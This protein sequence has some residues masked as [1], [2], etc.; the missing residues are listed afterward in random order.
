MIHAK[1]MTRGL[2]GVRSGNLR[3]LLCASGVSLLLL[4]LST[5][6]RDEHGLSMFMVMFP[7]P[8]AAAGSPG[9]V[10]PLCW[11]SGE[12]GLLVVVKVEFCVRST[13]SS[14]WQP[15]RDVQV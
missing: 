3:L 6:K 15:A 4:N 14:A 7:S 8:E 9:K 5:P 10:S 1:C 13:R 2:P 12:R 11:E